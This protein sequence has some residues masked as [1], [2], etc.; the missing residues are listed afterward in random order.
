[1]TTMTKTKNNIQPVKRE[2]FFSGLHV[3][4]A[5]EGEQ[6]SR[7]IEGYALLFGVRSQILCDWGD[8]YYEE[9]L[10]GCVTRELLDQSDIIM[11]LYH[12]NQRI[13]A[14][15]VMGKGSL[16]YEIDD[17]GVKFSFEAADTSDGNEAL[18]L[19]SRGDL[20]G[21][22]F[23]YTTIEDT[24]KGCVEYER[25]EEKDKW[26]DPIYLRKVK[27]ITGIYD[28]AIVA[29]PAY[30]ETSVSKRDLES[31]GMIEKPQGDPKQNPEQYRE[32]V[33][34]MRRVAS[35]RLS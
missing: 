25:T 32:Q 22:S 1:M 34:E 6:P 29:H 33:A 31:A 7:V 11:N 27:Q 17:K 20:Q 12:N 13:L 5:Q 10:P 2:V 9:L 28:F 15:S 14:R 23:C 21:C 16:S 26:G 8:F 18:S 4:E 35:H 30:P 19:V 3:R 24:S